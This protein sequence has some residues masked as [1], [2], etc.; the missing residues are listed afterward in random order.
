MASRGDC[1]GSGSSRLTEGPI[2]RVV[3]G[4]E[5]LAE[6]DPV[7]SLEKLQSGHQE[8]RPDQAV[9]LPLSLLGQAQL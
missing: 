5:A 4:S 6:K 8:P 9:A 3:A 7:Q 1:S 2:G